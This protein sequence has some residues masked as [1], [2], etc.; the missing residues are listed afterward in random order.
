M[1]YPSDEF[2]AALPGGRIPDRGDFT[3]FIDDPATRIANWQKAVELSAPLGEVFLELI[4]SGRI[5]D[6]VEKL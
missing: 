6:V 2:I 4:A 1:V 5:K 3:T